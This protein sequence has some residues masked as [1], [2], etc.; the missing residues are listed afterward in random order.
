[1]RSCYLL[2]IIGLISIKLQS[3]NRIEFFKTIPVI[4]TDT[5]NWAEL[6]YSDNPNVGEVEDLYNAYYKTNKFV[7][8]IHTQN[9]KHW[10][11]IVEPML[12]D[13]GFIKQLN[14][15]EEEKKFESLKKKREPQIGFRVP[16][17]DAGWVA[18]GP[19]ETFGTNPA[20]PISWHKNVYAI[21]QSL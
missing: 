10:I 20:I 7:K 13:N 19:F 14:Q 11:K 3:Q 9:H 6:M 15:L 5:P 21:D 16:G 17:S 8:T 4:D 2:L 12:D 18:M 1:M